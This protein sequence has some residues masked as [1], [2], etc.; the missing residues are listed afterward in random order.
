[1]PVLRSIKQE[2]FACA[3]AEG[4]TRA[5]AYKSAGFMGKDPQLRAD[6]LCRKKE[7]KA[8]IEELTSRISKRAV[9]RA[10]KRLTLTKE[11][12]L[13]ELWDNAQ[14]GATVKGGSSVRNRAL[15]LIGK[16]LGMFQD[17]EPAPLNINDL[18]EE[19]LEQLLADAHKDTV[20]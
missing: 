2:R 9:D 20:Q 4:M 10:A 11:M 13:A 18:T 5:E 1:M 14:K 15:E 19:Q 8:R 12:V 6:N 7:V 16:E 3:V 17:K